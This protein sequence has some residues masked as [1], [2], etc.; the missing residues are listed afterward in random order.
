MLERLSCL[1]DRSPDMNRTADRPDQDAQRLIDEGNALEDAGRIVEA[2]SRYEAAIRLAPGL[3]RAHLNLGNALIAIGDA[4]GAAKAFSTATAKDPE[5]FAAHFNLG[6]AHLRSGAPRAAAEAYRKAVDL[7]PDFAAAQLALGCA[8]EDLG[9]PGNAVAA[10]QRA[11]EID[12]RYAEAH[13]NL[14]NVLQRLQNLDDAVASYRRALELKPDFVDA[15]VNLG[16]TLKDRGQVA[17]AAAC[18]R[19]ALETMPSCE[20]ARSNL[21]FCVSHDEAIRREELF[22]EHCRFGDEF[23][24]HLRPN[25]PRHRNMRD[26]NR[27]LRVGVASG[28]LREHA[29]AYFVAGI[30]EHLAKASNLELHAYYNHAT[31]DHVSARLRGCFMDW[32]R[33]HHLSDA[34]LAAKIVDDGIDILIDLSGH[35]AEN[36]LLTFARKPAPVQAS[37]VGYPGTTGLQA[38]DYYVSDGFRLPAGEFDDQFVEKLVCLPAAASFLPAEAAP[39]IN[40]LP[41]L[42]NGYLTF[43]S[44]NRLS[45]ITAASIELWSRLLRGLPDSRLIVGA[46]PLGERYE[47]LLGRFR[48]HG[49]DPS[50]LTFHDRCSIAEY[51]KLHHQVDLCLDTYPYAG[52]TTTHHALW[53]GVPTL[54]L[55]GRTPAA[56]GGAAVMGRVGLEAFVASD[57]DDFEGKGLKWAGDLATLAQV[58]AGLRDRCR[59]SPT[60]RPDIIAAALER[61]L[62][63]MWQR[64]CAGEAPQAFSVAATEAAAQAVRP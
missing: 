16:N 42:T 7:R 30:F 38:M 19:R 13:Y 27:R 37:W 20:T 56:R 34:E 14:G 35:T 26:P 2:K 59:Q 10:Y 58:R 17:D 60:G 62:R 3:A 8:L 31:E 40:P 50:R 52:G 28:D 47:H 33:I 57:P 1:G 39:P 55:A 11:V 12:P 4:Q 32:H 15:H 45:K 5:Y 29:V 46:L 64:W 54:T 21:L 24:A 48:Q 18:F 61:A 23:E 41:A 53:M 63:V 25:W 44:F 36:R 51:L 43:G 9:Q 6:N 22:S 49:V